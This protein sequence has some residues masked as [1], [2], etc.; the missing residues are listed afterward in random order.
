MQEGADA[1]SRDDTP[2]TARMSCGSLDSGIADA[3]DGEDLS[4]YPYQSGK[5]SRLLIHESLEQINQ[6]PRLDGTDENAR[7]RR[8]YQALLW[9][10]GDDDDDG[11]ADEGVERSD[12]GALR[13]GQRWRGLLRGRGCRDGLGWWGVW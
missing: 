7:Q 8:A 3:D 9:G 12:Q 1:D 6:L 5:T 2:L 11:C 10:F 13:S 4:C